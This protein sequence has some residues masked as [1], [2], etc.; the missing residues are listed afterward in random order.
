ME[1]SEE[2]SLI[3]QELSK[4]IKQSFKNG[5]KVK[6]INLA[7]KEL[8]QRERIYRKA[9]QTVLSEIEQEEKINEKFLEC[10]NELI[11]TLDQIGSTIKELYFY[12]S[13]EKFIISEKNTAKKRFNTKEFINFKNKYSLIKNSL[14]PTYLK[15]I[16]EIDKVI[17][18]IELTLKKQ[19]IFNKQSDKLL[20][21][22]NKLASL[23]QTL[24]LKNIASLSIDEKN[25]IPESINKYS[26]LKYNEKSILKAT[27]QLINFNLANYCH[28]NETS[29]EESKKQLTLFLTANNNLYKTLDSEYVDIARAL[30]KIDEQVMKINKKFIKELQESNFIEKLLT[31]LIKYQVA[32]NIDVLTEEDLIELLEE[33][34][35]IYS[36]ETMDII[37]SIYLK[38]F[39]YSKHQEITNSSQDNNNLTK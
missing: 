21:L 13:K 4:L 24:Y 33:F 18:E 8:A 31:I 14:S 9:I 1:T 26:L 15:Q 2:K 28:T 25:K 36:E 37:H 20:E 32:A 7:Y 16:E 29:I 12:T 17:S 34:P 27:N 6:E 35:G 11:K 38:R 30:F 3:L 10:Y 39:F 23:T 19:N 22:T 5:K